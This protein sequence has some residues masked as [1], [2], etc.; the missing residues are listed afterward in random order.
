MKR[1]LLIL[2]LTSCEMAQNPLSI[3]SAD[4]CLDVIKP[5]VVDEIRKIG[6]ECSAYCDKACKSAGDSALYICSA[7]QEQ[8]RCAAQSMFN[9]CASLGGTPI[10]CDSDLIPSTPSSDAAPQ[11][12][13]EGT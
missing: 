7:Y 13:P 8:Y 2:V 3:P 1:V 6:R 12:S 5:F 9:T 11:P 10:Q 4:E